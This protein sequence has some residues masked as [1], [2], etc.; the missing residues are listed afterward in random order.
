MASGGSGSLKIP[1]HSIEAERGVLGSILL[2]P[3]NSLDKLVALNVKL[4]SFYDQR[5]QTLFGQLLEMSLTTAAMDAITIGQWLKE[6]KVLEK[7]G[8]YDYLV[9]LQD[10]TFSSRSY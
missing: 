6:K 1:P 10:S 5:H 7:V 9:E 8:G 2:D 4:E 3:R